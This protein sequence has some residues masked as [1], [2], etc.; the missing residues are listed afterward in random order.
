M[1]TVGE[2][3]KKRN[4]SQ[5]YKTGKFKSLMKENEKATKIHKEAQ[6]KRI[7]FYNLFRVPLCN[8]VAKK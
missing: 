2:E 5:F 1:Y 3:R 6:R 8:F 7:F 4:D